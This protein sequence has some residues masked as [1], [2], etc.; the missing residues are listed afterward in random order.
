MVVVEVIDEHLRVEAG[1]AAANPSGGPVGGRGLIRQQLDITHSIL[2][3]PGRQTQLKG[4]RLADLAKGAAIA[5]QPR[6]TISPRRPASIVANV[7][8]VEP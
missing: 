8:R 4:T 1:C 5:V 2:V 3:R 7:R 6:G